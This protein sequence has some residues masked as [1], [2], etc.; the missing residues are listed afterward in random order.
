MTNEMEET[1]DGGIK[2][3]TDGPLLTLHP[4]SN[5][6]CIKISNE[7]ALHRFRNIP[8]LF[9][10]FG[11]LAHLWLCPESAGGETPLK[12]RRIPPVFPQSL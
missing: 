12:V 8:Q 2:E 6:K 9:T 10:G 1:G 11:V 4:G 3:R 5:S 7:S